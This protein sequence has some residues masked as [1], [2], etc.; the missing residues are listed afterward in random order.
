MTTAATIAATPQNTT[1]NSNHLS[2]HQ[3]IRSAIRDS[4]QPTSPIG[5][6]SLKLPPPPCAV[7]LV[8]TSML[9]AIFNSSTAGLFIQGDIHSQKNPIASGSSHGTSIGIPAFRRAPLA[10]AGSAPARQ[11]RRVVRGVHRARRGRGLGVLH[12]LRRDTPG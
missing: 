10:R 12:T 5:L 4:Q 7:L 6:L 3:W 8:I 9:P 2:V 11:R 1:H